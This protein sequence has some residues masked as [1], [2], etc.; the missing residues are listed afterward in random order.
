[1]I[2]LRNDYDDAPNIRFA[3]TLIASASSRDD[4]GSPGRWAEYRLYKTRDG[5]Y[6]CSAVSKT[7]WDDERDWSRAAFCATEAEVKAFFGAGWLARELYDDAG[8]EYSDDE[9]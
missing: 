6:A 1:M 7:C 4:S 8:I 3:G 2:T 9:I 5:R